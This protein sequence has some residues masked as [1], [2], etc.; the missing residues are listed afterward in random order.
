MKEGE[1]KDIAS[2]AANNNG[3]VQLTLIVTVGLLLWDE[4]DDLDVRYLTV[5]VVIIEVST[6]RI[7]PSHYVFLCVCARVCV[8]VYLSVHL[9]LVKC[10]NIVTL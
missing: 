8:W 3:G 6:K 9:S 7:L 4:R 1:K 10:R 5:A 2:S